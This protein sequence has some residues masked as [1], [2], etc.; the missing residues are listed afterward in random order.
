MKNSCKYLKSK[1][2][3][4]DVDDFKKSIVDQKQKP[5]LKKD[6]RSTRNSRMADAGKLNADQ[7]LKK[8]PALEKNEMVKL[9]FCFLRRLKNMHVQFVD[10]PRCPRVGEVKKFH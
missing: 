7:F 8:Y 3:N 4:S 10:I 9:I 5:S 6:L 2:K 1:N